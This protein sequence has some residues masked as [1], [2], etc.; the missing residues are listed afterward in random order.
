MVV[1]CVVTDFKV[2]N[3]KIDNNYKSL[4]FQ[5]LYK[6]VNNYLYK[7]VNFCYGINIRMK[8]DK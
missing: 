6:K 1:A 4:N 3:H 2:N 5:I 8:K 7:F